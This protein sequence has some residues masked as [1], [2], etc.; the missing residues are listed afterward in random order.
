MHDPNK[1]L[2]GTTQSSYKTADVNNSD[3]ASFPAGLAVRRN[4]DG[5][6]SVTKAHGLLIGVSLG[7]S[8]SDTKKTTVVRKGTDIPILLTDRSTFAELELEDLTF[9]A[10]AKGSQGNQI[11]IALVNEETAGS[12]DVEVD[13]NN[14]VVKIEGGVSTATQ[15]KAALD[16]SPEAMALIGVTIS[17]TAGNAQP[18]ASAAPLEDGLDAGHYAVKGEKVYINDSTG[19]ADDGDE[20]GT[21]ITDAVYA[22]AQLIGVKEDKTEAPAAQ[23]DIIGVM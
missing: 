11:T 3:P 8:L 14:I 16:G 13:G 15:V 18:A 1:V 4:S 21:T 5:N 9:T 12:E 19:L 10:K 17:G 7:R 20:S 2:L 23:I 22:S 6:L